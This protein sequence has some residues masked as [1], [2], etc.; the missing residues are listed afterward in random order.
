MSSSAVSMLC[1]P[2]HVS[3]VAAA[4]L[5]LCGALSGEP[6]YC[7]EE[8]DVEPIM[9]KPLGSIR[10]GVVPD[11]GPV[12]NVG[13]FDV[14]DRGRIGFVRH[15]AGG[16]ETPAFVLF[17]PAA[18]DGDEALLDVTPEGL[19]EIPQ[20]DLVV[21][22]TG[23][24]GWV[25][26]ASRGILDPDGNEPAVTCR[27][28]RIDPTVEP[29]VTPLTGFAEPG[30]S[31][32][33][34]TGDGG[35]V[36]VAWDN[37]EGYR[38]WLVRCGPDGG[39][40]WR[41]EGPQGDPPAA[42]SP[43]SVAVSAA[44]RVGAV[45]LPWEACHLWTFSPDGRVLGWIGL[46]GPLGRDA[47]Y[48]P[49]PLSAGGPIE[50]GGE[51]RWI[52][53][54]GDDLVRLAGDRAAGR[55]TPRFTDG[56]AVNVGSVVRAP[57]D[58]RLWVSEDHCLL[59]LD[60]NGV[61]DRAFGT[62]PDPVALREVA[63]VAVGPT[64]NPHVVDARTAAVHVFDPNGAPLR[65]LTPDPADF[66]GGIM[67]PQL[68]FGPDDATYLKQ[69]NDGAEFVRFGP[70]GDRVG[71][72]KAGTEFLNTWLF[73]PDGGRWVV[74]H[75][76]VSLLAANGRRTRT[77]DRRPDG[78]FLGTQPAPAVFPDGGL[79]LK[80]DAG[81]HLYGPDG[82]PL[83]TLELPGDNLASVAA[84]TTWV[85]AAV[86]GDV[87]LA[88][89]AGGAVRVF[90]PPRRPRD[91]GKPYLSLHTDPAGRELWIHQYAAR[92]VDRYALP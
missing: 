64:G 88:P 66:E 19:A 48:S 2:T 72:V 73:R 37:V 77:I 36:A 61:V 35:F 70:G 11:P 52:L 30:L 56:R 78:E 71:R 25:V 83:R 80:D 47:L 7:A 10:F 53:R 68:A 33:H 18:G 75:D 17:D 9:L 62:L 24:D 23:G 16:R 58:G 42:F 90:T 38:D 63:G 54:D 20:A 46:E 67:F 4:V 87:F 29:A 15:R 12:R 28:W 34:G 85:A 81:T 40:R 59:R 49:P 43:E 22:W 5:A 82:E 50:E 60:Q 84:G 41:V 76:T 6:V 13:G 69:G 14:D 55:I 39:A 86:G 45:S 1:P 65:V 8:P 89:R 44:G 3:P 31:A 92:R 91:R 26:A 21:A 32:I 27:A 79:A 51:D 57:A 74:H